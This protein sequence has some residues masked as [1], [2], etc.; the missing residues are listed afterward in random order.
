MAHVNAACTVH[1]TIF[2]CGGKFLKFY[3]LSQPT[4]SYGLASLFLWVGNSDP[5]QILHPY[6]THFVLMCLLVPMSA[7]EILTRFKFY[8]LT[9]PTR[10]YALA[11]HYKLCLQI[12]AACTSSLGMDLNVSS[13]IGYETTRGNL[14]LL[15]L[16]SVFVAWPRASS[17]PVPRSWKKSINTRFWGTKGNSCKPHLFA[18]RGKICCR[19]NVTMIL[20][21]HHACWIAL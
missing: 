21:C 11:C 19:A 20:S 15:T 12:F 17:Y 14:M 7:W 16:R 1:A 13:I 5:F 6:S 10:S 8:T 2:N 18:K 4:R 9:Q 3:T